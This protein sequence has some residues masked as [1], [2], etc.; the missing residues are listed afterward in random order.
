MIKKVLMCPPTYF[1]IE[2]SINPYM[3]VTNR[4][5]KNKSQA[6]WDH[7]AGTL[8]GLGVEIEVLDPVSGLPDMTFI[9]DAGMLHNGKFLATNFRHSERQGEVEHY[10]RWM[11]EHDVP[12]FTVPEHVCFE[13]LGDIVY[14]GEDILF[15]YG[16]RSSPEAIHHVREVYPELELR[17]ELHL[18]DEGMY[19]LGLA[20]SYIDAGTLLYYPGAFTDES[21]AFLRA[22]FERR[23]ECGEQDAKNYFVCNNIPLGRHL[24][25]DNCT[26]EL[27]HELAQWGYQVVKTDMS[28]FKK[29][30]GSVRCL[31]LAIG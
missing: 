15:G 2:Y 18:Q 23:I 30:G 6:Q 28:E 13:G 7:A 20:V 14:Y 5:D 11:R 29:S 1:D 9:G 10:I 31:I 22:N 21:L 16:Q 4:V 25:M 19:H 3:D 27:G 17:G 24:L 26:D 8:R 12:V